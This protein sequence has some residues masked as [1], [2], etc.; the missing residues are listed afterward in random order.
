M[1]FTDIP[2]PGNIDV[3]NDKVLF[4]SWGENIFS[5]LIHSKSLADNLRNYFNEMWLKANK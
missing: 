4:V 1:K 2:I 5:V 3:I